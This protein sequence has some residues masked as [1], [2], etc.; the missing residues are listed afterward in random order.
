MTTTAPQN[1]SWK[2]FNKTRKEE[3][4]KR[5]EE[6]LAKKLKLE[7]EA[8][9]KPPEP[10]LE[11]LQPVSTLAIAVPGSILENAQ[12]PELRTYLAGQIARAACVF[13]VDEVVVFDDCPDAVNAKKSKLED[14]EGV[15]TARQSCVQLA[16]ILQ[17]LE[18]PQYLRKHFF[19]I[20]SDLKFA[21]VL[22]PLDAPH[23]LRQKNDFIFREGVVTNKPTKVGKGSIVNVGLLNDVTVD[24]TLTAGL[25]V[26]V[27]LNSCNTENEKKMKG[28]IVSP[29]RPRAE[30]G[31]Y[32]GYTV[33][34]A[35]SLS[36]VFTQS[37]YKKGYDLLIGTSDKGD[38]ILEKQKESLSYDHAII[39]FG[40]L[41][42]LET[43]LE[44]D[45]NLTADDPSLLFDE[46]LNTIPNQGSRTI[47]TEEAILISLAVLQD[48]MKPKHKCKEFVQ[49]ADI[50]QSTD[51]GV[52]QVV[53]DIDMSKFD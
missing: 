10:E 27:K 3:R 34:I 6:K 31:V 12:S 11:P 17:Y 42:G 7:Q 23:H 47:R 25:R 29:S 16:R 51:T 28:L 35:N 44:S 45:D 48:K 33:R 46:Y 36:E 13:Q 19:P 53:K 41:L 40:G 8:L 37:P 14:E 32:W 9:Q 50:A 52:K 21:G 49:N 30:T 15:K 1:G 2:E 20:H 5:T 4:K 18:C 38:S 22:N 43:A 26:T 24:K 39:V